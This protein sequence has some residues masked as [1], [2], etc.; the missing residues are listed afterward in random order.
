LPSRS[1]PTGRRVDR[2][3]VGRHKDGGR[4]AVAME[5]EPDCR[6]IGAGGFLE[7]SAVCFGTGP[8]KPSPTRRT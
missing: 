7:P 6:G 3:A 5:F 1:R 8:S 4:V 2:L